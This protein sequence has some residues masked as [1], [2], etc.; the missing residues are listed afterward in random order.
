MKKEVTFKEITTI[1]YFHGYDML[2]HGFSNIKE[3]DSDGALKIGASLAVFFTASSCYIKVEG[4]ERISNKFACWPCL[5]LTGAADIV[6][7]LFAGQ[8]RS[9]IQA[10]MADPARHAV[11]PLARRVAH[12][13]HVDVAPQ[14]NHQPVRMRGT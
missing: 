4:T 11:G 2:M 5:P 6:V 14:V 12:A 9:H 10:V 1:G 7:G 13:G 8:P 3:G